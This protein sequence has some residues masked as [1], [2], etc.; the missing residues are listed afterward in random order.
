MAYREPLAT[1]TQPGIITVG[2]G[3]VIT[4]QG[5]L[6]TTAVAASFSTTANTPQVTTSADGL[7]IVDSMTLV[8]GAGTYLATFNADTSLVP[9]TGSITAQAATDVNTLAAALAALP[10][11]VPH[12][13]I[14]GNGEVLAPGVYDTVGAATIQGVLTLDG[15]GDPNAVFVIR[16][17]G[18]ITS[19]AASSVVLINGAQPQ[20]VF[21]R[22]TGAT[23]LGAATTFVGTAVAV[24]GA[25]GAGA[26][27]SI[28]G[29][30]LSTTGA[31]TTDTNVI[32]RPLGVGV[33]PVG[34]L[35]TFA[36][37]T[38]VGNVTNTGTSVINGD[39]GT[40]LGVISGYGLPTVVNGN[41]YPQGA[42]GL[43]PV[44]AN[45]GIYVNGVL[46]TNSQR[47]EGSDTSLPYQVMPLQ[48][49]VVALAGQT[50]NVRS[51]VVTGQLTVR[52]RIFTLLKV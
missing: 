50:V 33:I 3:L 39:I 9:E 18:A 31:I 7:T 48:A 5:V 29:R 8:P 1:T 42:Q 49:T 11:G 47:T 38:A 36:L 19:V 12:V 51:T 40:N 34:V 22:S 52:N 13:A 4:P 44:E 35:Q 16:S 32:T 17:A 41:I 14:F 26:A 6:S 43:G 10:G 21:W 37:F 20:N 25:A 45:F 15:G 46:V 28:N 24:G 30:L 23:A 27:T 2:A